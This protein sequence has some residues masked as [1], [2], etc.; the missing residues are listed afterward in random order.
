MTTRRHL[1]SDNKKKGKIIYSFSWN[2]GKTHSNLSS[3]THQNLL[4]NTI[5]NDKMQDYVLRSFLCGK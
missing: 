4:G 1:L 3:V 2:G 5:R